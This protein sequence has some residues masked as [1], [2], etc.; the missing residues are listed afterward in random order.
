MARTVEVGTE[1][2]R[3]SHSD[4]DQIFQYKYESITNNIE[5]L[6]KDNYIPTF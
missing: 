3:H 5:E 4:F 1:F 6:V 2:S